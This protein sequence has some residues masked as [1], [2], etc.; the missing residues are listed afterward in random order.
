MTPIKWLVPIDGSELSIEAVAHALTLARAGLTTELVLVNVQA[1]AT[2]YEM[3][4]LHDRTAIDHVAQAAG[5]DVLAPA[6]ALAVAAQVPA[7]TLVMVGDPVPML[8][9]ALET[10]GCQGVIMGSQ[11]KGFVSR[12]LLGSVSQALL[13]QSPVPLTF[14][15]PGPDV[16]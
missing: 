9:E 4:T 1:P 8:L 15:T 12:A 3:V 6:V 14:V 13:L 10:H 11:G 5:L 16:H 2:V 7:A